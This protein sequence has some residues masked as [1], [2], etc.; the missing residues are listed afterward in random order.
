[1]DAIGGTVDNPLS[2]DFGGWVGGI[3]T[4][5]LAAYAGFRRWARK[6]HAE[7]RREGAEDRRDQAIGKVDDVYQ[8]MIMTMQTQMLALTNDNVHIRAQLVA[9][10][11]KHAACQDENLI[12]R[13]AIDGLRIRIDELEKFE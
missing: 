8:V 2:G 10:E 4:G 5:A 7:E 12:Q 3:V 9:C 13:T 6:E 11:A 1:M